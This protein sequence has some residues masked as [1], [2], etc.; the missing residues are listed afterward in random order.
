MFL[1]DKYRR[2]IISFI[3]TITALSIFLFNFRHTSE[4]G[5]L[6]KVSLEIVS[7]LEKVITAPFKGIK[8]IWENYIFLVG[9]RAEN[10]QLKEKNARAAAEIIKYRE[11]YLEG[12]R[13]QNLLKLR[14]TISYPTLAANV[15]GRNPSSLFKMIIINRG[16]AHGVSAGMPVVANGGVVGRILEVSWHVSRVLLLTDENSN[17]DA[18]MLESRMPGILQG[19]APGMCNLKYMPKTA[20]IKT[21]DIIVTSGMGGVFPKGLPLG[22]VR[23]ASKKH[24][25]IFQKIHVTP[26][27]DPS[28]IEE[29]LVI[30]SDKGEKH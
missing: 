7:T 13:L 26:F 29:V 19:A 2:I 10:K 4:P 25:D 17:I 3:I 27:V 20:E 28:V 30:M 16:E 14:E 6:R 1:S 18:V 12:I 21:G 8:D 11:V 9:L 22:F 24:A 15:V 23:A 5:I